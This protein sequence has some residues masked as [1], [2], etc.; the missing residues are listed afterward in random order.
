VPRDRSKPPAPK[1]RFVPPVATDAETS[2]EDASTEPRLRSEN[3]A[4]VLIGSFNPSI[5]QPWWMAHQGLIDDSEAESAEVGIVHGEIVSFRTGAI[6]IEVSRE[7]FQAQTEDATALE[8]LRDLVVGTFSRLSHTPIAA[9][10]VNRSTHHTMPSR[11]A[12]NEIG[13]RLLPKSP[14]EGVLADPGTANITVQGQRTD[15]NQGYVRAIFEPSAIY[16]ERGVFQ[17]VNDHFQLNGGKPED[18]VRASDA[19]EVLAKVWEDSL[20]RARA[21]ADHILGVA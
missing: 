4:V 6:S 14:W 20:A 9:F 1:Q 19:V 21:I 12:W 13:H 8:A 16:P 11:E 2:P 17:M 18:N 5:F 3:V 15:G 10:G 7:R